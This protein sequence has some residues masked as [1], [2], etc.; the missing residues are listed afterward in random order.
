[1]SLNGTVISNNS[2]I[3]VS[4]IGQDH[5]ALLC[6]TDNHSCCQTPLRG[7]EWYFPNGSAVEILG[8]NQYYR[9]DN[10]FYRNRGEGVVRLN[11]IGNP[12]ESGHFYCQIY[13]A[14]EVIQTLQVNIGELAI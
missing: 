6:H 1:M 12:S 4:S 14:R 13:D 9:G 3:G 5:N 8:W 7:G 11:R 10:Y 2:Y